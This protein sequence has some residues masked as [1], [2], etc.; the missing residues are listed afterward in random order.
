MYICMSNVI[1]DESSQL[2][3]ITSNYFV[4]KECPNYSKNG[5][6]T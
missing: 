6:Y 1:L 4:S 5:S 3:D 2:C